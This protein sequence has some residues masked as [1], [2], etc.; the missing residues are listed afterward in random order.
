VLN[1]DGVTGQREALR[2]FQPKGLH[3]QS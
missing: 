2:S 3:R 1:R